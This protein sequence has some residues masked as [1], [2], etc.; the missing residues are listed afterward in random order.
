MGKKKADDGSRRVGGDASEKAAVVAAPQIRRLLL[1]AYDA[2]KRDLPWRGETDPYRIWVSEVMLQQTRVETVIPYYGKWLKRFPDLEALAA[3]EE[4]DVLRVWQGLGYYSR[5]RRLHQGARVV[6]ER[7]DGVLP[8]QSEDLRTLPGVGE[9]TAGAVASIAFGE[10][11]PAVD[12]N[13]RR[14]LARLFDLRDPKPSLLRSLAQRLV[15]PE[16]PGEF[17]QALMELG[18]LTC[19]PRAPRCE[20]CPLAL[21]CLALERGTV[22]ER[23]PARARKAVPEVAMV[24]LVA[25]AGE[26]GEG[27]WFLLRKRSEEGLLA[28]MWEFPGLELPSDERDASGGQLHRGGRFPPGVEPPQGEA[29]PLDASVGR[30]QRKILVDLAMVVGLDPESFL[31]TSSLEPDLQAL[32]VVAHAFSHLRV[33]YRP[34]LVLLAH[35][36]ETPGHEWIPADDLG[37]VPLPVAQG[38]I[39]RK[40]LAALRS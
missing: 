15:D 8:E 16:R 11:V 32:P 24:V 34:F 14:V 31:P 39:A 30:N 18:A 6:R 2:G 26:P 1:S 36:Q 27:P 13:V 40:A 12:G 29:G 37:R 10:V 3:A 25:V 5:A 20:E 38:K 22:A 23:P 9:Y 4:D 21:E 28:G 17:N 7:F 33:R 19:T 35:R